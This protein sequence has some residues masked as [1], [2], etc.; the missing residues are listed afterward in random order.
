[1]ETEEIELKQQSQYYQTNE[2]RIFFGIKKRTIRKWTQTKIENF[3][4]MFFLLE[5]ICEHIAFDI[6]PGYSEKCY[7]MILFHILKEIKWKAEVEYEIPILYRDEKISSYRIDILIHSPLPCV[8]ELKTN[9]N[10]TNKNENQLKEYMKCCQ[11]ERGCLIYF[12]SNIY[13]FTTDVSNFVP[14]FHQV[15]ISVKK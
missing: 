2:K 3:E 4:E 8:I 12:P 13:D 10:I 7:Q 6:G 15:S 5:D 11:I 9:K 14:F 1:M